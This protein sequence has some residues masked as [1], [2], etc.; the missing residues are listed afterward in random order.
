MP[1]FEK[2]LH[3]KNAYN[4]SIGTKKKKIQVKKDDNTGFAGLFQCQKTVI[5]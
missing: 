2:C 4:K 3:L 1:S 5:N